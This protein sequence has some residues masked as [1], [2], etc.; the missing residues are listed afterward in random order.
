M[1]NPEFTYNPA[2]SADQRHGRVT[3]WIN[4]LKLLRNALHGEMSDK[5]NQSL[6]FVNEHG[7][8][9]EPFTHNNGS[10]WGLDQKTDML[11]EQSVG[12]FALYGSD[13]HLH[14]FF[15][16]EQTRLTYYEGV[17]SVFLP[18]KRLTPLWRGIVTFHELEHA[19]YHR[20]GTYRDTENG[21]WV[22][23][24]A[25]FDDE[26]KIVSQLYGT[27]YDEYIAEAAEN[28][29]HQLSDGSHTEESLMNCVNADRMAQIIE[30]NCTNY[31]MGLRLAAA[32]FDTFY[33]AMDICNFGYPDI[34]ANAGIT[35]WVYAGR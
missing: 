19:Q 16:A 35:K 13:A 1:R 7:Y 12:I 22:E 6:K 3:Q 10:N 33:T 15:K 32:R 26:N 9:I 31:E 2:V 29:A 8:T 24:Q 23:E 25:I 18:A 17:R 28:V 14:P 20:K 4:S 30:T 27:P 34:T 11:T 5:V 21:H